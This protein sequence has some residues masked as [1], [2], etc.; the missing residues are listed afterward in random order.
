LSQYD[1]V[2]VVV[3][4]VSPVVA[5]S[6]GFVTKLQFHCLIKSSKLQK[7]NKTNPEWPAGVKQQ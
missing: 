6:W 1:V 3:V 4:V 5:L 7:T 2:P